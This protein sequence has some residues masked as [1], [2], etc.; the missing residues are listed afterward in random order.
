MRVAILSLILLLLIIV[1]IV[2]PHLPI[3]VGEGGLSKEDAGEVYTSLVRYSGIPEYM[4]PLTVED[5]AEINA[6]MSPTGMIVTTGM[7]H[8]IKTK[9]EL[10]AVIGHEMGHFMLQHFELKGDSRLHEANAD[11]VGVY[12]MLRAGYDVC[13]AEKIWERLEEKFGDSV[14]TTT[15]P[16][17]IQR[18][19]ELHFPIC[20]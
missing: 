4:P 2:L 16:G 10:A 14:I 20:H 19:Y 13:V 15:H 11:K 18:A 7:L 1:S 9:D 3:D 5:S 6:Y 17:N 8:F 12:L